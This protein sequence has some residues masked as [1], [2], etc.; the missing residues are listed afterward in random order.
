MESKTLEEPLHL[1]NGKDEIIFKVQ[2]RRLASIDFIKG[3]AI[4]FIILAH[5]SAA[6]FSPEWVFLHGIVYIFLDIMGPSLFIFLSALSVVFSINSKKGRIPDRIIRNNIFARGSM[7]ILVGA[8]INLFLLADD[9][10]FPLSLWGWNIIFFLGFSQI[11]CYYSLKFK[12]S[13]RIVIGLLII[14]SSE[15]LRELIWNLNVS[16]NL[17]GTI[18]FLMIDSYEN[19]VTFLPWL[20][21]CF[22]TTIFGEYLYEAMIDGSNEVYHRLFNIFMV[23]GVILVVF[24]IISGLEVVN[25]SNINC[26]LYRLNLYIIANRQPFLEIIGVWKFLLRGTASNMLYN[27]G[28]SLLVMGAGFYLTDIK[29]KD[30]IFIRMVKFYGKVSL[31]IFLMH[32][33]WHPLFMVMFPIWYFPFTCLAYGAFL[34]FLFYFWMK[35]ANYIGTPEWLM[36]QVLSMGKKPNK[37]KK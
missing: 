3:V 30:N 24:G 37:R 19:T 21:I 22:I 12:K 13:T 27:M 6:W 10:F 35:Y 1:E 17:L 34:G 15:L 29:R 5:T 25:C 31:N 26:Y 28:T 2:P 33:V 7:L 14:I 18:L 23:F 36:G 4:I 11:F 32:Y 8:L 9:T 20:S 16:G